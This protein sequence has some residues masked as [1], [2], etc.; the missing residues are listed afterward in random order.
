MNELNNRLS[1]F[2]T[3]VWIGVGVIALI[4]IIYGIV[5]FK[6]KL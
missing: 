5:R 2:S 3:T 1:D 6:N 4:A